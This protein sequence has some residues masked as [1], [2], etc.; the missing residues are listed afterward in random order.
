MMCDW[1]S[2]LAVLPPILKSSLREERRKGLQELR[3]RLGNEPEF[4]CGSFLE[5]DHHIVTREDIHYIVNAAS[6]YSPWQAETISKGYLSIRGG[7]RIGLSGEVICSGGV[8]KGIRDPDSLCIRIAR[9]IPGIGK[10][11]ASLKG[12]VLILGAPGWGKTTLLRDLARQI[13]QVETTVVLDER[14]ELFPEGFAR[15][16][17]MDVLRMCPKPEG[18]E[19]AVRT[20]GAQTIALDEITAEEDCRTLI[21]GANCGVRFLST[22]HAASKE[23]LCHRRI[24][25]TLM[26]EGIFSNILLLHKDKTCIWERVS[27]CS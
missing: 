3:L 25:R 6:R 18:I 22:V 7:H 4:N 27:V 17:R 9:D 11:Y 14:G 12:S 20:M 21:Q 1:D 13:A 10:P 15:G 24:C 23:D 8:V 2:L 26:D 16:K 5:Y 19:L